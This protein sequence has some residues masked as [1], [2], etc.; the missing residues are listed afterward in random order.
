MVYMFEIQRSRRAKR[1]KRRQRTKQF[2]LE[3]GVAK[4]LENALAGAD[5]VA[6]AVRPAWRKPLK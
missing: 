3:H 4:A 5:Y 2:I 6:R 1:A